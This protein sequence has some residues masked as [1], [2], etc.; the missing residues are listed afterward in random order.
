MLTPC[1]PRSVCVCVRARARTHTHTHTHTHT[2]F[3]LWNLAHRHYTGE[4]RNVQTRHF[5]SL[6]NKTNVRT[7]VLRRSHSLL[8]RRVGESDFP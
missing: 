4:V 5:V 2:P 7:H 6:K 8:P 1:N 3:S